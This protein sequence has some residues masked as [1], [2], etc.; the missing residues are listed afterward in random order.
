MCKISSLLHQERLVR[1]WTCIR[2]VPVGLSLRP[3]LVIRHSQ[4]ALK[5]SHWVTLM[6]HTLCLLGRDAATLWVTISSRTS[7]SYL[8]Q[9][10]PKSIPSCAS[11]P[12]PLWQG[13]SFIREE[14]QD[15]TE[16]AVSWLVENSGQTGWIEPGFWLLSL[17]LGNSTALIPYER[18]VNT[19]SVPVL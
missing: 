10:C 11:Q 1:S 8:L 14:P 6:C 9:Y 16:K 2:R 12:H 5:W 15:R 7:L 18:G 13:P 3:G 17:T 19:C 4:G